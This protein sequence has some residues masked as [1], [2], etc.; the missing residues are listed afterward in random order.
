MGESVPDTLARIC[1]DKRSHIAERKA[2]LSFSEVEGLAQVAGPVRRFAAALRQAVRN[3]GHGLIAEIKRASPSKGLIRPDFDPPVLAR[4]YQTGGAACLSVLTDKPYFQGDD[5]FLPA[6]RAA[7]GLP[8]LRKDFILD[9]YQIAEARMLGADAVLLI[10]AALGDAQVEE[11]AAAAHGY[12]MTVLI[13]VHNRHELKRAAKVPS[14][15]IGINNRDLKTLSVNID[16]SIAIA[17]HVPEGRLVV[18]ESGITS[19]ADL[20]RLAGVG[21]RCFLVGESLMRHA[22]VAAATRRL[23]AQP[24][25]PVGPEH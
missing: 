25:H 19:A 23:L 12:G 9:P 7:C 5:A 4:A 2:V 20:E 17:E 24:A 1:A 10:M 14:E 8:T 13:E 15:I 6:A 18:S 11:L 21:I 3:E 22:D 16:V